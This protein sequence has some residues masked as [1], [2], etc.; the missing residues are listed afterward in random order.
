MKWV[1][2]GHSNENQKKFIKI[3]IWT[4]P[5][6]NTNKK[7]DRY[8]DMLR[9]KLKPAVRRR[10]R[11]LLS[12]GVCLQL[13]NARRFTARHTVKQI[14]DLKL[15]VLLHTPYSPDLASSYFHLFWLLQDALRGRHFRSDDEV[16]QAV[17]SWL[18]QQP[19]TSFLWGIYIL[20]KLWRKWRL[21]SRLT[22][23]YVLIFAI[24]LFV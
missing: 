9:N 3:V 1:W 5:G 11:G 13:D 23:L 16:K 17:H 15:A 6:A 21:H 7:S 8:S 20:V 12:S 24:N 22:L 10:R 2:K 18:A 4:L 19:N 14:Q